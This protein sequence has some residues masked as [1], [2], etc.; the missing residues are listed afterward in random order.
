[1][2]KLDVILAYLSSERSLFLS[3]GIIGSVSLVV[4]LLFLMFSNYKSFA[5]TMIVL[6]ILEMA[7]MLPTYIKYQQ[8]IDLKISTY[9]S[10]IPAFTK[11]EIINTEKALKSFFRL[12]L[13]YGI[14]IVLLILTM[15]FLSSKSLLFGI[16]TALI[17]HLAFAIT[18]DNFGEKYTN[19]YLTE[20]LKN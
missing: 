17:I 10:G 18:I 11:A 20:L 4:G 3:A 14:L 19:K 15:S 6:G 5:I 1:M 13:F 9:E 7:V 8:K 12:K 2:N 16:F